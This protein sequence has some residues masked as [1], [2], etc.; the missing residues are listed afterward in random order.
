MQNY[1]LRKSFSNLA[2]KVSLSLL[3]GARG[4]PG[5]DGSRGDKGEAGQKGERVS[6]IKKK[7]GELK[8]VSQT[9]IF[10]QPG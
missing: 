2:F 6:F 3:K 9:F 1:L 5:A 10:S 8:V 7:K 4:L